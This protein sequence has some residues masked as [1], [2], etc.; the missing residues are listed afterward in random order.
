MGLPYKSTETDLKKLF[1]KYGDIVKIKL[2]KYQNTSKNE[3]HCYIY[4]NKEQSAIKSLE[5]NK[6]KLGKRYMEIIYQSQ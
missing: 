2:P 4:Y 3:G 6:H 5:L 1:S